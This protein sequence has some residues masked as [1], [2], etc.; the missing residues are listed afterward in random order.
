MNGIR[1][2]CYLWLPIADNMLPEIRSKLESDKPCGAGEV[3]EE[4]DA[5]AFTASVPIVDGERVIGEFPVQGRISNRGFTQHV[6]YVAPTSDELIPR[7]IS[8]VAQNF[9]EFMSEFLYEVVPLSVRNKVAVLQE[10]ILSQERFRSER[11]ERSIELSSKRFL[12]EH[13]ILTVM[14]D[15]SHRAVLESGF[16][17]SEIELSVD[18]HVHIDGVLSITNDRQDTLLLYSPQYTESEAPQF[19][20]AVYQLCALV[21]YSEF[22]ARTVEILK[23]T[24]DHVIPLRRKMSI[25]LQRNTEEYFDELTE[26]KKYLSYV[27]VKL[28]VVQKIMNHLMAANDEGGHLEAI[29]GLFKSPRWRETSP[30]LSELTSRRF[31]PRLAIKRVD[32]SFIRIEDL[33]V[34]DQAEI[35]ILSNEMS[36]V[37]E[38]NM[39]SEIVH[40]SRRSLDTLQAVLELDRAGKNRANALKVLSVLVSANVGFVAAEQIGLSGWNQVLFASTL[41]LFLGVF[42]EIF[43]RRKASSFRLVIPF[44]SSVDSWNLS[45]WAYR[46]SSITSDINGSRRVVTWRATLA[47]TWPNPPNEPLAVPLFRNLGLNIGVWRHFNLTIDFEQRG[48]IHSITIDSE[49]R[50]D[51]FNPAVLVAQVVHD[52]HV[53]GCLDNNVSEET[54][55]YVELLSRLMIPV[56]HQYPEM[57]RIL[58]MRTNDLVRLMERGA[59]RAWLLA[60]SDDDRASVEEILNRRRDYWRWLQDL[61]ETDDQTALL[62]LLGCENV[63]AKTNALFPATEVGHGVS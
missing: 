2:S 8:S 17:I 50:N 14:L 41:T 45:N 19:N 56:D 22:L 57:N 4:E 48:Y 39:T 6:L 16:R 38:G 3:R 9:R 26:M 62:A 58:T 20:G 36:Q 21:T 15:S 51:Q 10:G 29:V 32:E 46:L 7:L 37:L 53:H 52:M 33:F 61:K 27:D 59:D 24:R 44:H 23:Q 11:F 42:T 28:P 47:M 43:I 54:S 63:D 1:F 55:L 18:P 34:E 35:G 60:L 12:R 5:I 49:H 40:V 31:L 13:L 30:N 25:Y